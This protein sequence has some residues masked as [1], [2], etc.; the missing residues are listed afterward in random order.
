MTD[1]ELLMDYLKM[2]EVSILEFACFCRVSPETIYRIIRGKKIGPATSRKIFIATKGI[3]NL[4]IP[5]RSKKMIDYVQSKKIQRSST[6][7]RD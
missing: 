1:S 4:N 3:V 7:V 2:R 5:Y 6:M